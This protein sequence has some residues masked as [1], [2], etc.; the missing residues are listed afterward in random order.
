MK[1][2]Q[3]Q[4]DLYKISEGFGL[5]VQ[6]TIS[7]LN[8]GRIIGRLGEFIYA[9][10][11]NSK[12][13]KSEGSSYDVDMSDG[14]RVEVRSITKSISFASSKEVG[15][16]RTVT[17]EGFN[18]KLNSVDYFIGID[19]R[20]IEN[21]KFIQITKSMISDMRDRGILRKNKSV[22]AN[23]FFKFIEG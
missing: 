5:T 6:D 2:I 10:K 16:G 14:K 23:K 18:D 7:F 20:E 4:I 17:E 9:D 15:Y 19:Y 13:A 1:S 3:H 22:S 8:D 21:L 11:T 12:R